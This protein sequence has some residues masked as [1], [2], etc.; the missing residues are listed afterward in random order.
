M[1]IEISQKQVLN[2]S[3]FKNENLKKKYLINTNTGHLE[4]WTVQHAFFLSLVLRSYPLP[5]D[6]KELK[7][8]QYLKFT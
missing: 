3:D 1:R 4:D 7:N 5:K 2:K 8:D 6:Q